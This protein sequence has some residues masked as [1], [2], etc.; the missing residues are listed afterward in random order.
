MLKIKGT[1]QAETSL[2]DA[3]KLLFKNKITM[4]PVYEG[5]SIIGIVRDTDL[6]LAVADILYED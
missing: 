3:L 5:D 2:I 1:I 4:L 6:F